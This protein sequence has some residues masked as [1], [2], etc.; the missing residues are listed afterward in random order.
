MSKS[1]R[2]NG[3][4]GFSLLE[5]IVVMA[6]FGVLIGLLLPAIQ[7]VRS[8]AIRMQS[9]NQIRQISLGMHSYASAN[10]NALPPSR[11]IFA[12][13]GSEAGVSPLGHIR[14]FMDAHPTI[15]EIEQMRKANPRSNWRWCKAFFSPADPTIALLREDNES[16][17]GHYPSSYS[18]N[19]YAFAGR[20]NLA[21]SFSDGTSNT[22]AFAERYA[23]IPHTNPNR[24]V[25]YDC[26]F[27]VP[28]FMG[29]DGSSRRA[30]FA[31]AGWLD[32]VPVTT[33]NP[34]V[35]RPSVPGVTFAVRP[36]PIL[37]DKHYLQ[38][39]HQSGLIVANVDGSVRTLRPSIQETVFWAMV[40][41]DA[42]E[43]AGD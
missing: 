39:L 37:A 1:C 8:A 42:G 19:M 29:I 13:M 11:N 35:S 32:V 30:T 21:S 38:A 16:F 25:V 14:D 36:E 22:I 43:I 33:G 28:A 23:V 27:W 5:L 10:D 34:P 4:V 7:N 12:D 18:A 26:G 3:R 17:L 6:I 15:A 41:R 2:F 24:A 20:P 9:A 31:D 40:T